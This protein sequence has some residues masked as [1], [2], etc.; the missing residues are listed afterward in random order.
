MQWVS[1]EMGQF[2]VLQLVQILQDSGAECWECTPANRLKSFKVG[3][4]SCGDLWRRLCL[5]MQSTPHTTF[6]LLGTDV[7]E[8]L[9]LV[10]I[11]QQQYA[12]CENCVDHEFTLVL[13]SYLEGIQSAPLAEQASLHKDIMDLLFDITVHAAISSDIVECLNGAV[14]NRTRKF[15]GTTKNAHILSQE[16][17]LQSVQSEHKALVDSVKPAYLPPKAGTIS[18]HQKA[19]EDSKNDHVH[20]RAGVPSRS[21]NG[22]SICFTCVLCFSCHG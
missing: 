13:L 22:H 20:S 17:Y 2:S 3:V 19:S 15:R 21:L 10:L 6:G 7:Y 4:W 12:D 16:S 14:Q 5:A 18:W 1:G 11:F 9:T 8:F